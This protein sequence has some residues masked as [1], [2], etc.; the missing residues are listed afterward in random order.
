ME[1]KDMMIVG[2]VVLLVLTVAFST[3]IPTTTGNAQKRVCTDTDGNDPFVKGTVTG[4]DASGNVIESKTDY[5]SAK[6]IGI[7]NKI[8]Y[9]KEYFCDKENS[10]NGWD[11][12]FVVCENGCADGACIT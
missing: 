2:L 4:I 3:G 9:V 6:T 1:T 11:V 7:S 5:C 10:Y 12:D 8:Y